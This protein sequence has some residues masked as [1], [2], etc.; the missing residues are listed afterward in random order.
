MT[1]T[2][3][4]EPIDPRRLRRI[5]W[6]VLLAL[7][8]LQAWA[9]RHTTTPDGMSYLDISDGVVSGDFG[10]LLNAYWSP[11]YPALLGA[12]R[13][14]LRPGAYWEF[15]VQHLL[16][17]SLFAGSIAAFEY[18]L[19][20]LR[21]AM[22]RWGYTALSTTSGLLGAWAVFG[23]LSLMMTPLTLPTPDLLVS[24]ATYVVFGALVRLREGLSAGRAGVAL[25]AGLAVG[26]LAKSFIVPW[27]VIC[28]VV[29]F[30]ASRRVA[31]ARPALLAAAVWLAAVLPWSI[32]LSAKMGYP[33]FGDTGRLT[34]AWFVNQVE[35]PSEKHMP[36]AAATPET[37]A[38][39]PG[40]AI[41]P[42]SPSTHPVWYDPARYY[43]DLAPSFEVDKQLKVF[44]Y[45]VS[46]YVSSLAPV[47]LF[48]WAAFAVAR[49]EDRSL[50]WSR[51]WVVMV[52]SLAAIGAYSL[53]LVTT[54]YIAPF[55]VTMILAVWL[56]LPWPSRITP[57]RMLLAVGIPFLVMVTAPGT[58][59]V[60]SFEGAAIGAILC[61]WVARRWGSRAM[62]IAGIGGAIIVKMLL[63]PSLWSFVVV[64]SLL[65]VSCW[66]IAARRAVAN[67]ESA[68]LSMVFRRGLI[69]TGS[70]LV[71][72][73]AWLKYR[74]SIS[75]PDTGEAEPNRNWIAARAIRDAGIPEGTRI[76]LVG[77]PFEAYWARTARLHI[78]GV[79]PPP[80]M[81]A[82]MQLEPARREA[83]FREFS[84][85]GASLVVVQT[86]PTPD[87]SDPSWVPVRYVGWT[88]RI[89]P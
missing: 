47:V 70:L 78:V 79:V 20:G 32:A 10:R 88:K 17:L 15:G 71:V 2:D 49:R 85:A 59:N 73:V 83:L 43:G 13:A 44:S 1:N 72:W 77:S 80:R 63:P 28:L 35:T 37:N 34:Y 16:N 74:Q 24:S 66:W 14:V 87:P 38:I 11:L 6:G 55:Y 41:T 12:L 53:V 23:V 50:W 36:S 75:P 48:L 45:L 9:A 58:V 81:E 60:V 21:D 18:F 33:T 19:R 82:Y 54:R 25:G 26:S 39:L 51:T 30:V 84:R 56:A 29:A 69:V 86:G 3:R 46:Q 8:A 67:G 68:H 7:G 76:A 52:P 4:A 57:T 22:N 5:V 62:I 31:G 42:G 89:S 65:L 64:G 40:V 27:S 61:A